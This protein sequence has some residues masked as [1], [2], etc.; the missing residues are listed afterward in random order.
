M[1]PVFLHVTYTVG[2][3]AYCLDVLI[4]SF[5]VFFFSYSLF[6]PFSMLFVS[7]FMKYS[8][9]DCGFSISLCT[10]IGSR[11]VMS[12]HLN[13]R[14]RLSVTSDF[15]DSPCYKLIRWG[16]TFADNAGAYYY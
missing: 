5:P 4:D 7:E 1:T 3:L 6:D 11:P 13:S 8:W 15:S 9:L 14:A 10:I 12:S 16:I 2:T